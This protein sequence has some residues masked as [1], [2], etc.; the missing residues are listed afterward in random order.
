MKLRSREKSKGNVK[1]AGQRKEV[2]RKKAEVGGGV[3]GRAT[4]RE[5]DQVGRSESQTSPG[6]W[7]GNGLHKVTPARI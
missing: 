4:T 5:M 6:L 3:G 1:H 2:G 7:V